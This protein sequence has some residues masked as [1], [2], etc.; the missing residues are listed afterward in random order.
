MD[1]YGLRWSS[2]MAEWDRMDIST[3]ILIFLHNKQ[4]APVSCVG[5]GI[6]SI[7]IKAAWICMNSYYR[8]FT[9]AKL[10][11]W[12]RSSSR[13]EK[14]SSDHQT[15]LKVGFSAGSR[16]A[17]APHSIHPLILTF[18]FL[19]VS[20]SMIGKC[21]H[22]NKT[23]KWFILNPPMLNQQKQKTNWLKSLFCCLKVV[24]LSSFLGIFVN[25]PMISHISK[26]LSWNGR[27]WQ[28]SLVASTSQQPPKGPKKSEGFPAGYKKTIITH[29]HT[30]IL[31]SVILYR[32]ECFLGPTYITF[33]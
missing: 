4:Q 14:L 15:V 29:T 1:H 27:W 8:I 3:N 7:P 22:Q 17:K 20:I 23:P 2:W 19:K 5:P 33:D 18:K 12:I 21:T 24:C 13:C 25:S 16:L 28:Q 31:N 32:I 6:F 9:P 26:S 30:Y 11:S 10:G